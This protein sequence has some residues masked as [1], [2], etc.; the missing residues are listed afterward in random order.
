[1]IPTHY[2]VPRIFL[3]KKLHTISTQLWQNEWGNGDT[4]RN[5]QLIFP[6]VKSSPASWQIGDVAIGDGRAPNYLKIFTIRKSDRCGVLRSPLH[7]ATSCPLG[8]W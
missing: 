5:V 8:S 6:K 4:S 2:P 3:K 7:L 1:M